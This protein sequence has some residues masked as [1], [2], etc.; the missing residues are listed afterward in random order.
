MIGLPIERPPDMSG[1]GLH[2]EGRP[3]AHDAQAPRDA[4]AP[5]RAGRR[6]RDDRTRAKACQIQTDPLPIAADEPER[7]HAAFGP[8]YARLVSVKDRYDPTNLFRLNHN[9][10]PSA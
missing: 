4:E 8:N 1:H 5:R 2:P 6:G 9:I 10:R 7:V 3:R